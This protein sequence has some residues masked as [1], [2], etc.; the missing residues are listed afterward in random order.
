MARTAALQT[1]QTERAYTALKGAILRGKIPEG[2]F[3]SEVEMMRK[4]GIGRTPYREAC[5]RLHH[6]GLLE[7]VPRRGYRIPEMSFSIVREL[8]EARLLLEGIIAELAA[9]RASEEEISELERLAR[10]SFRITPRN[11]YF[12]DIIKANTEFHLCLAHMTRNR[13]LTRTLTNILER[14]QRLMYVEL[15]DSAVE[16]AEIVPLHRAIAKAI[17]K[18]DPA[19][20]REAVRRDVMLGQSATLGKAHSGWVRRIPCAG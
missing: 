2:D 7:V 10:Q 17:R 9:Q 18:R 19:A 13:E 15:R 8:F 3:L 4:F 11:D 1:T 12:D 16:A 20:A 6:E 14:T 5:N